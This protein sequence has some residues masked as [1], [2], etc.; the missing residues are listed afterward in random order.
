MSSVARNLLKLGKLYYKSSNVYTCKVLSSTNIGLIKRQFSSDKSTSL[1]SEND[2]SLQNESTKV[3]ASV[4]SSYQEFRDEDSPVI[5]DV[6]EE[7]RRL[8]LDTVETIQEAPNPYEGFEMKRGVEGVFDIEELVAFLKK[9]KA[10]NIF[11]STVPKELGYVDYFVVVTGR[12]QRHMAALAT[13]IRKAYKLKH[14]VTDLIPRLEGKNS[15]D[16][17]ALDLGN[18]VLHI[19]SNSAREKF[20]LETLWSIG[21]AYDEEYNKPDREKE[22]QSR[23]L[24]LLAGLE[25]VEPVEQSSDKETSTV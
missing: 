17:M 21:S 22:F 6:E 11:V 23:Y 4:K 2:G 24:E 10:Q 18:I 25:P 15:Q 3:S 5:L 1:F 12:S 16:W 7:L 8:E 14:H 13:Y 20:D 19:F 9:D